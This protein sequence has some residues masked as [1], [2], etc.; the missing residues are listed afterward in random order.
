MLNH[1]F[2]LISTI[3]FH[4][5]MTFILN[6]NFTKDNIYSFDSVQLIFL[7]CLQKKLVIE[8]IECGHHWQHV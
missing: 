1:I 3:I 5:K 7:C 6:K 4:R 2:S 8:T